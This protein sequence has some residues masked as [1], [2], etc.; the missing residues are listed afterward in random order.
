M[1]SR[2]AR[3]AHRLADAVWVIA[4][5]VIGVDQLRLWIE[6]HAVRMPPGRRY[7]LEVRSI[8]GDVERTAARE[9]LHRGDHAGGADRSHGSFELGDADGVAVRDEVLACTERDRYWIALG[10]RF[11]KIDVR[12]D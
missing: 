1:P 7:G 3:D 11:L 8:E 5:D 4:D 10:G 12:A 9:R 2:R 6:P